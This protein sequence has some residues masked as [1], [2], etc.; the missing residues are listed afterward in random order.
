[1]K[2]KRVF[3]FFLDG[4][5]ALV[6]SIRV[7]YEKN[8]IAFSSQQQCTNLCHEFQTQFNM[9]GRIAIYTISWHLIRIIIF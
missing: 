4:K 6:L 1:M 2:E 9:T 8:V 5:S 7:V 3:H